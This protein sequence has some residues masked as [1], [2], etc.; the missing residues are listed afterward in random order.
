MMRLWYAEVLGNVEYSFISM[1]PGQIWLG[2][3]TSNKVL[4]MGQVE[5][6]DIWTECKQMIYADLN[7]NHLRL[8]TYTR[9]HLEIELFDHLTGC[10]HKMCLPIIYLLYV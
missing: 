2:V 10:T 9:L 4:S 5:L 7:W 8:L 1:F 3:V 6:I